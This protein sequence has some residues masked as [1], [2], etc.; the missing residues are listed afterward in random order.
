MLLLKELELEVEEAEESMVWIILDCSM[1]LPKELEV[2]VEVEENDADA[3]F[4]SV[5]FSRS[6]EREASKITLS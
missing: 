6:P 3:G 4:S 5:M 1:V 2:A